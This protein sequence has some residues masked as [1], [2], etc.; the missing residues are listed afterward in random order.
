MSMHTYKLNTA[1]HMKEKLLKTSY[2]VLRIAR[3]R[4]DSIHTKEQDEK[5]RQT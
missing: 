5:L 3:G 1:K 4:K 2:K